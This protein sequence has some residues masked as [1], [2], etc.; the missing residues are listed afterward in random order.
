MTRSPTIVRFDKSI[1][2]RLFYFNVTDPFFCRICVYGF[3]GNT[4]YMEVSDKLTFSDTARIISG[5]FDSTSN[6]TEELKQSFS[7]FV[8]FNEICF[9]YNRHVF[10]V[11]LALSNLSDIC[12]LWNEDSMRD[13]YSLAKRYKAWQHDVNSIFL[14]NCRLNPQLINY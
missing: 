5:C 12:G 9:I 11:A 13:P 7:N 6:I 14:N 1:D 2:N 8:P 10:T 4:L 3:L